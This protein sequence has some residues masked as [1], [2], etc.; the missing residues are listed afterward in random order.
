MRHEGRGQEGRPRPVRGEA[1]AHATRGTPG[2]DPWIREATEVAR[3]GW[4]P[5][6][7]CIDPPGRL[8]SNAAKR[9]APCRSRRGP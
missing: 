1:T 2:P 9:R 6:T 5:P 4:H 8:R 7:G 3:G